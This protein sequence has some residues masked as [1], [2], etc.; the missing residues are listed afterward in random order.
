MHNIGEYTYDPDRFIFY[1]NSFETEVVEKI[2]NHLEKN[3]DYEELKEKLENYDAH[4][5]N[6]K[7]GAV[8]R[9]GVCLT[10]NCNLRC[11]YCSDTS[12]EGNKESLELEDVLTFVIDV[13]K[14]WTMTKF[15]TG[16]EEPLS[17]YFTGGGEPTYNWS[18]FEKIIP[19]IKKKCKENGI[20]LSL[21]IT[22]NGMLDDSQR[23]F[24]AEHFDTIMVSYDGLPEIQN[25]NR[26]S[27]LHSHTA[28]VVEKTIKFFSN[29]KPS[30]TIRTTIWQD[31]FEH[32][33]DM[34]DYIFDKFGNSIEWSILPVIPT[35]RALKRILTEQKNLRE[36]NF[37]NFYLETIEY[38]KLKRGSLNI[39]TPIFPNSIIS[40]YC[41][42]I[43]IFCSCL[44]LLP[45]KTI[46]TC[47]ESRDLKTTI[48]RI[49][50]NKVEYFDKCSDHLL[51]VYQQKFSECR[52][53]IAYRFC[54]GGC[55]ARHLM[56]KNLKTE[57]D[58][59]ECSMIQK[60][61]TYVFRHILS[62]EKCFG[63]HVVPVEIDEIKD[64]NVLKLDRTE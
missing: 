63:W 25:K 11:N 46:V 31:D 8:S 51:R 41:G 22:T 56:N 7:A 21:G 4:E 17:L 13:M 50:K 9:A 29:N 28:E 1:K 24:I 20:P 58:D 53:C 10:N 3:S 39:S 40:L 19:T 27:T 5:V 26:H 49:E 37:L 12:S 18:L 6:I 60:Y 33:K 55:P 16:K 61:W 57:M 36:Y 44:W 15:I 23:E 54:K 48:G 14:R 2:C 64:Y 47:I 42:A 30:L 32:M 43:S 59:W 45:N 34:A 52:N 35:G 38:I 62:G